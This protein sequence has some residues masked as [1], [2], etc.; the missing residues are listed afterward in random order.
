MQYRNLTNSTSGPLTGANSFVLAVV[1]WSL[2]GLAAW[3]QSETG[4]SISIT[5]T[6]PSGA[7]IPAANLALKDTATNIIHKAQTQQTGTYTFPNLSY[8]NYE[9]TVTKDGF[10]SAVFQAIQVETGRSTSI[11][12]KLNV[13]TTQQTVTVQGESPLVETDSSVLSD[14]IDTKQVVNL[15]LQGRNMFSLAFLIP[16]WAS[17]SPGSSRRH[18]G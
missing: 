3:A 8:G 16:G 4:G 10:Q 9:L 6:D 14:T 17:T 15:P 13:G 2:L 7:A 18:L 1:A 5:V 12:A 11:N